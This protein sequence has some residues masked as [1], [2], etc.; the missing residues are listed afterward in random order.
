MSSNVI[1]YFA[2][3]GRGSGELRCDPF[4]NVFSDEKNIISAA[5]VLDE[6]ITD[7]AVLQAG[8]SANLKLWEF[9]SLS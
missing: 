3:L 2:V 8:A 4:R 9:L 6:A 7:I 5:E 1:D